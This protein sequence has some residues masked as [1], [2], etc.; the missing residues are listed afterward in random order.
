MKGYKA[1]FG[2]SFNP[3]HIGHIR[4]AIELLEYEKLPYA[5][6]N[7]EFIPCATPAI[8]NPLGLLPFELRLS[9]LSVACAS[10]QQISIN[11]I[12]YKRIGISYTWD[13][14]Q[15]YR[16]LLG[17]EKLL[18]VL[19]MENFCSLYKWYNGLSIPSLVSLGVMPR[20][21]GQ[22]KLFLDNVFKYWPD[23]E[24]S[25]CNDNPVATIFEQGNAQIYYMPL[26]RMEISSTAIRDRWL[27]GKCIDLLLPPKAHQILQANKEL[28]QNIW[29]GEK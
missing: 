20:G 10:I 3:V 19:G 27:R 21:G 29:K 5:I 25:Y 1:L 7:V 22:K 23:A 26:P 15:A 28:A 16:N 24:I 13:T 6:E 8:K 9:M 4:L 12:E 18:F 2:G 11:D 14:L 17:Q